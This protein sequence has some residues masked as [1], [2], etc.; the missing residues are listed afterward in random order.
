MSDRL[1]RR[2]LTR[3]LEDDPGQRL[4]SYLAFEDD[5]RPALG[6]RAKSLA[7]EDLMSDLVRIDS[8]D[9]G[10]GQ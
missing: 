5:L 2:K 6:N 9:P 4:A 7:G 3:V 8:A 10:V 1:E